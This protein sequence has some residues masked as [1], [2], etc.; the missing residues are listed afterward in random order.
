MQR[1]W[2]KDTTLFVTRE[3]CKE[4]CNM[5]P[6]QLGTEEEP[7]AVY[8]AAEIDP[9]L[10]AARVLAADVKRLRRNLVDKYS[11]HELI[12]DAP[13]DYEDHQRAAAFL[14]RW[15]EEPA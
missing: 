11:E 9:L 8:L 7:V 5:I 12:Y 4:Q 3:E 2:V 6:T 14:E 15:K 10:Q 1:C 13:E